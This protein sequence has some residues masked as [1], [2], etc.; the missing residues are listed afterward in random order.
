MADE[1]KIFSVESVLELITGR[2]NANINE[3]TSYILG[4]TVDN[5][6]LAKATAPF[7]AAW[8]ARWYPRFMDME[9][10]K[11][12]SWDSFVAQAKTV[13]GDNI[14]L[15][16][17]TGRLKDLA[18]QALDSITEANASL[19]RQTE[20][21][22]DL[23]KK[24]A[25][26]EPLKA[27]LAAEQKKCSGL[28]DKIKTMKTEMGVLQRKAAEYDGKMPVDHEELLQNIRDAIKDGLKGIS[29][30]AA[31]AGTVQSAAES[32]TPAVENTVPED[33]GFGSSGPDADG[34]GF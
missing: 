34:F 31:V 25:E 29:I 6:I 16:P 20:A 5:R 1:R 26:L 22:V 15:T 33:F 8:L 19:L 23:E 24:V 17:M 21:N 7:A 14:S 18:T 4:K 13:L 28:E 27:T 30:G 3:I 2:Q 10:A 12:Q 9:P 32:E 11:G